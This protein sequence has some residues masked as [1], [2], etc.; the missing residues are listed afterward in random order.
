MIMRPSGASCGEIEDVCQNY[1]GLK[2]CTVTRF[3]GV[4][5]N[6]D[7]QNCELL[8]LTIVLNHMLNKAGWQMVLG[9]RE[10]I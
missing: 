7:R 3:L 6:E 5:E 10:T 9:Y 2:E 8:F 1:P 4:P